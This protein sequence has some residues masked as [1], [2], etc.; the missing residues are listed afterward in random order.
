M[1]QIADL[2]QL[3]TSIESGLTSVGSVEREETPSFPNI[4]L[5]LGG[6][7]G[8]GMIAGILIALVVEMFDLRVRTL[9]GLRIATGVPVLGRIPA[10]HERP[11]TSVKRR[12]KFRR[13]EPVTV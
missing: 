12:W 13:S 8:I 1:K 10:L 2:R 7:G 9:S 4:P 11:E 3:S 5:I 6:T